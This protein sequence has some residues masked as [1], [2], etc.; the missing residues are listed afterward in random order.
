[1]IHALCCHFAGLRALSEGAL[2]RLTAEL[3]DELEP[4]FWVDPGF[5]GSIEDVGMYSDPVSGRSGFLEVRPPEARLATSAELWTQGVLVLR[6][7]IRESHVQA[8]EDLRKIISEARD[9]KSV[10]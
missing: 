5:N 6:R 7:F 8:S 2:A 10:V 4:A 3:C 1:M 9:R